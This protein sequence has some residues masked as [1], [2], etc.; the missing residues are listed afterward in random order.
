MSTTRILMEYPLELLLV[1]FTFSFHQRTNFMALSSSTLLLVKPH[2]SL[3]SFS[4]PSLYFRKRTSSIPQQPWVPG[5]TRI[6]V[7]P[8]SL[9]IINAQADDRKE[10]IVIVG[11]GI[12]GLATA[13]SLQRFSS[14]TLPPL[15]SFFC[16]GKGK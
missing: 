10:D 2:I 1:F 4:N 9:S 11:A 13:V 3:S 5:E 8:I 7:R 12:A 6:R 14:Q 16:V 15:L